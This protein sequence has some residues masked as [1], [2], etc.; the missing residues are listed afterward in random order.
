MSWRAQISRA[1]QE[2]RFVACD[3]AQHSQGL[4]TFFRNNYAELKMLNP[5]TPLVYR[6]AE[7]MQPFVYARFDWGKEKKVFVHNKSEDEILDVLKGL[8]EY[9][10]ALPKSAES[11]VL[12]AAP[13]V[14]AALGE[15]AYE[16]INLTWDGKTHRRNP[17]F[18]VPLE[19]ALKDDSHEEVA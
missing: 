15:D 9:G 11:D 7:E 18:D 5:C 1:I 2:V 13:I 8:V 17:D 6:E 16:P 3:T 19:E 10:H 14:D 4:R 12:V